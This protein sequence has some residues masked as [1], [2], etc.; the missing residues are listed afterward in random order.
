M[1][2]INLS[3]LTAA[4]YCRKSQE[5][6]KRQILSL[7]AQQE[8]AA[9]LVSQ[10]GIKK[11]VYYEESKSA[12]YSGSRPQ[13][14]KMMNDIRRKKINAI[15]CWKIDR[16]ARNM[17][18]AGQL[19][20][21][22]QRGIIKAIITPFKIYYSRENAILMG[23]E[24]AT[25]N[26][27][28]IDLSDNVMRG[29]EK[30][31]RGGYPPGLA[32]IGFRND[33]N[34]EKGERKWVVDN[35]RFIIIQK[36]FKMYLTGNFSGGKIYEWAVEYAKLNTPRHKQNGGLRI[37]RA[38]VYRMLH[39]PIYAGIFYVQG[40][41]Y[42]LSK[43]LPRAITEAD[44][45]RILRM[46]G[47]NDAPKTQEHN[48]LYS[49]YIKSPNNE[50]IGADV[51]MHLTCDCRHKF[52]YVKKTHCPKCHVAIRQLQN[53][54]YRYYVYY[55]NVTKATRKEP[56]KCISENQVT[57]TVVDYV[58]DNLLFSKNLIVWCTNYFHELA[59]QE[60]AEDNAVFENRVK[61]KKELENKKTRYRELLA[62]GRFSIEEYTSDIEKIEAEI[63]TID[64]S[65]DDSKHWFQKACDMVAIGSELVDLLNDGTIESQ[66]TILSK[67]TSNLQW[68]EKSLVIISPAPVLKLIYG[69]RKAIA[70][71]RDF[72]PKS[73]L[74]DKDDTGV[75]TSVSL[76]LRKTLDNVRQLLQQESRNKDETDK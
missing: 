45:F 30:K 17:V 23:V 62:E 67:F 66:R 68:N 64:I 75:F 18:E 27:Y 37:S 71:N 65:L 32:C 41:R 40:I 52:S 19:I 15:I 55:R 6:K 34:G 59:N 20:D 43:E 12:R 70:L 50:H 13:F 10:F 38:A 1:N 31:A 72:E 73:T 8:E 63:A 39:S 49:G 4:I 58:T 28:S 54:V 47:D 5:D 9:K 25:A 61:R 42:E 57:A 7:P 33:K 14:K 26:Q 60:K 51:K 2:D 29:Q 3:T 53:P 48:V 44:H 76:M 36:M 16:L 22:L 21:L 24:F 56:Y 46:L 74:A 35:E 11:T 69:M